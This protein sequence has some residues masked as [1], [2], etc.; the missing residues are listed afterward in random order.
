MNSLERVLADIA[1]ERAAQDARWGIQEFPDGTGP[2]RVGMAETARAAV[3]AANRAGRLTW[4][5][6]LEEEAAEAYA[7][8]DRHRLRAELVQTAAVAVKWIEALDRR[9]ADAGPPPPAR[10]VR[11]RSIVDVHVLLIRDGRV[12]LGRRANTGYA[13]G[14]WHLPSGHMEEG[15]SVLETAVREAAEEVGVAL[16]PAGLECV[17]VMHHREPGEEARIGFFFAARGWRGEPVNAEPHKC[18]ELAW[19][20]LDS[21]PS[22]TVAY[23]AAALAAIGEGRGFSTFG[24]SDRGTVEEH[25]PAPDPLG[26]LNP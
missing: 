23:P 1:A 10:P 24:W 7:E 5:E 6:I 13:D 18:A 3:A 22:G 26:A 4:R 15:E 16:D 9:P 25:A 2:E 20:A 11:H 19:F 21:L 17:H 8:S 12:L 14:L